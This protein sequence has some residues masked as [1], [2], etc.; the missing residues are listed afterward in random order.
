MHV[1]SYMSEAFVMKD[2][3]TFISILH[4]FFIR[5]YPINT[6]TIKH[7]LIFSAVGSHFVFL[8]CVCLNISFKMIY[9]IHELSWCWKFQN[10]PLYP[11]P[12]RKVRRH[13]SNYV[14]ILICYLF[15]LNDK[16]SVFIIYNLQKLF[17]E[18]HSILCIYT[19]T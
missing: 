15:E 5:F 9:N 8:L 14:I 16:R 4:A 17:Y 1:L 13:I 18:N 3:S 12:K 7:F 10:N 2:E 19:K 6:L 11:H